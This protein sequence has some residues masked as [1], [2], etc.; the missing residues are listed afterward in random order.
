MFQSEKKILQEKGVKGVLDQFRH[1]IVDPQNL[2]LSGYAHTLHDQAASFG[3]NFDESKVQNAISGFK[4]MDLDSVAEQ[5]K[6]R[7]LNPEKIK[8]EL[9]KTLGKVEDF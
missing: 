6:S 4:K 2:D 5:L 3:F 9:H 8:G 7:V 1:E